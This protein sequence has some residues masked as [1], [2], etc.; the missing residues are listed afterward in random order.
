M[1]ASYLRLDTVSTVA[2]SRHTGRTYGASAR[3]P[4]R[5]PMIPELHGRQSSVCALVAQPGAPTLVA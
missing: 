4:S 1:R 3:P 5:Q 2:Q